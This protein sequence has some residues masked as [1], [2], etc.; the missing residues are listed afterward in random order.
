MA[1]I[2]HVSNHTELDTQ[3]QLPDQFVSEAEKQSDDHIKKTLDFFGTIANAQVAENNRTFV[4][5]YNLVAGI[6]RKEDF[7]LKDSPATS[8]VDVLLKDVDLPE[9]VKHYSLLNS[10]LSI[11]Q[12]EQSKRP[13]FTRVK[14]YDDDS[15]SEELQ[16]KTDIYTQ[17][18]ME[19][20][21]QRIYLKLA[22]QGE[23][24]DPEQLNSM[25]MEHVDEY[26]TNYTSIAERWA[27]RVLTACKAEFNFKELS[28]ECFRD[29]LIAGREF[30][31]VYQDNSATG[32]GVDAV[33]AK[34]VWW[35]AS[36]DKKYTSDPIKKTN[37][38]YA[39]GIL[40]VMELGEI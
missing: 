13:D 14:A 2:K 19:N 22:G 16:Y 26:L 30:F 32:F 34:N 3:G 8:F 36:P 10:P 25:T 7:Y 38:A 17:F 37:G 4:P 9:H 35:L 18:V 5:N 23:E 28:E 20:A 12:G 40:S 39:A 6:L 33:N 24:V 1:I 15:K 11:M 21:K 27:N 31:H 29:L